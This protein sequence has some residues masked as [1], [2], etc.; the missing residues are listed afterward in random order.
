MTQTAL[1]AGIREQAYRLWEAAGRPE[2]Y[3][4]DH[5]LQAEVLVRN[6]GAGE[7]PAAEPKRA[8][9]AASDEAK[10]AKAKK[11]RTAA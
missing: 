2:G 10:P 9:K 8:K 11:A 6:G 4:L 1:D 5:W 3:D 7:M